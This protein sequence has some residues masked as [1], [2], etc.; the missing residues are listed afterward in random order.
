MGKRGGEGLS[1]RVR[2][3]RGGEGVEHVYGL[4]LPQPAPH[5]PRD[6]PPTASQLLGARTRARVRMRTRTYTHVLA[7]MFFTL[8][9]RSAFAV[10]RGWTVGHGL[11]DESR[12]G[13]QLLKDYTAGKLVHCLM[14]PGA[15]HE[16]TQ[17]KDYTAGKLVH[18]L[19]PPGKLVHLL[20]PPEERLPTPGYPG[21]PNRSKGTWWGYRATRGNDILGLKDFGGLQVEDDLGLMVADHLYLGI[22]I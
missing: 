17:G 12:A 9:T 20:M 7:V 21:R 6:T 13:R 19:M 2:R 1:A 22:G 15:D 5:L 11:P 18:L 16:D 8:H 14:P 3:Q 4:A 10:L